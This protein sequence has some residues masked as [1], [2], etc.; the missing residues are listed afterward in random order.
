MTQMQE[1][2]ASMKALNEKMV[3]RMDSMEEAPKPAT[4]KIDNFVSSEIERLEAELAEATEADELGR[5]LTISNK[6]SDLK[7]AN[8]MESTREEVVSAFREELKTT[9]E[10]NKAED[11][12]AEAKKVFDAWLVNNDWYNTNENA[13]LQADALTS[14]LAAKGTMTPAQILD[15]VATHCKE[16]FNIGDPDKKPE[17]KERPA[18]RTFSVETGKYGKAP[19]SDEALTDEDMADIKNMSAMF[20]I[21]EKDLIK[22]EKMIRGIK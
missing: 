21:P 2:M 13:Q 14:R 11:K 17:E 7:L 5:A 6:I 15:E 18:P 8:L 9:A 19:T 16:L 12:E 10:A 22:Q 20:D 1:A 4:T 3:G